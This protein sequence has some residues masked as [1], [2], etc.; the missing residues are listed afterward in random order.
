MGRLRSSLLGVVVVAQCFP[1]PQDSDS[2]QNRRFEGVLKEAL[3]L[4]DSL[5][6]PAEFGA[7]LQE[8]IDLA[9]AYARH[10]KDPPARG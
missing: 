10:E 5:D 4:A 8:L 9:E 7:R 3:R 2:D 1:C 6:L